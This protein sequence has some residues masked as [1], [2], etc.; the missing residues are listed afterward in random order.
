[1]K[2]R[3]QGEVNPQGGMKSRL[4]AGKS[5]VL[6][7]P[8]SQP[9]ADQQKEERWCY[10]SQEAVGRLAWQLGGSS[11]WGTGMVR[12]P[13][14]VRNNTSMQLENGTHT[15]QVHDLVRVAPVV[16]ATRPPTLWQTCYIH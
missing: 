2:A 15:E 12:G 11:V 6:V 8:G 5:H 16:K 9:L 4:P 7:L 1:M 13:E 3:V 10:L 14:Q